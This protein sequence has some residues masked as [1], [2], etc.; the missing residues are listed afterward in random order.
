M[1]TINTSQLGLDLGAGP[2]QSAFASDLSLAAGEWPEILAVVNAA[3]RG[4][5]FFRGRVIMDHEEFGGYVY[6][7]KYGD[8]YLTVFND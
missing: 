7:T 4:N 1:F 5:L 2:S 3:G 8:V 6:A